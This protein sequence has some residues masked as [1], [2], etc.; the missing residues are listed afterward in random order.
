MVGG[1]RV[2]NENGEEVLAWKPK[3]DLGY[4]LFERLTSEGNAALEILRITAG[5]AHLRLFDMA[6][7]IERL[8]EL[9]KERGAANPLEEDISFPALDF[10]SGEVVRFT[11]ALHKAPPEDS[12]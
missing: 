9:E 1:R 3:M 12:D 6:E 5:L 4:V 8:T 2:L 11:V 10:V 7:V